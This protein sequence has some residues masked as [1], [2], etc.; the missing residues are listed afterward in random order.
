[1]NV[2]THE[3]TGDPNKIRQWMAQG[4]QVL[5]LALQQLAPPEPEGPRVGS[6]AFALLGGQVVE[7]TF[8]H[9]DQQDALAKHTSARIQEQLS[10]RGL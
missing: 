10:K 3:I 4:D 6:E 2:R 9:L 8:D 1:M 5:W 7:K